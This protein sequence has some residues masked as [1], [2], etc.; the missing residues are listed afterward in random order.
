MKKAKD[1]LHQNFKV[2]DLGELKYF[3]GIDVWRSRDG[4]LLNQRKYIL[5]LISE[6]GLS[7]AKLEAHH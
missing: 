1:I 4:E 6:M 2:N 3:L 5:E 7:G